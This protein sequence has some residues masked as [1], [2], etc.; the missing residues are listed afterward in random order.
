[1]KKRIKLFLSKVKS[2]L[3]RSTI[4]PIYINIEKSNN[5]EQKVALIVGGSG[6][7]GFGIAKSYIENGAKVILAGTNIKKLKEN[8]RIL[9]DNAKFIQC[10]IENISGLNNVI[11]EAINAFP[12]EKISILVNSAGVHSGINFNEIQ[13][14]TYDKIM[15]VN[16]KGMYFMCQKMAEYMILNKIKGNILNVSSA[17]ALK[18]AKTPYELSKWG[19][20]GL[21][22]GLSMELIPYGI[23][24]NAIGPGPVNTSMIKETG[25][26]DLKWEVNPSGRI[27]TVEE[28][29]TWAVYM[30]SDIGRLV[31]GDT[32]YVSGGSGTICI[33]K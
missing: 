23:V 31:V 19:V 10:D 8:C 14:K 25:F 13:E 1:M 24:V 26:D 15:N 33:D 9:G 21:T 5:L 30:V 22:L 11:K 2:K 12:E 27:A 6:G 16:L 4:I 28:I 7:I 29:G 3:F 18:P 17:S 32:F 20:K